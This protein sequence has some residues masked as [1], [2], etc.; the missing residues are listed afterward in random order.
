MHSKFTDVSSCPQICLFALPH[1][2]NP[3]LPPKIVAGYVRVKIAIEPN[4][5]QPVL[6]IY[7]RHYDQPVWRHRLHGLVPKVVV[8]SWNPA[9]V[10]LWTA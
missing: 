5:T 4:P 8:P 1:K 10:R 9:C 7:A 2:K 6:G 3:L